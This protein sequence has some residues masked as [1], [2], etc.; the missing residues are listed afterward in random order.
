M[1]LDRDISNLCACVFEFPMPSGDATCCGECGDEAVSGEVVD[2]AG[3]RLVA[4]ESVESR[5]WLLGP[6]TVGMAMGWLLIA[7]RARCKWL[8][9]T[10][11]D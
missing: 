2:D 9:M 7:M 8:S 11:S 3:E 10:G 1:A 4:G 5:E 6:A